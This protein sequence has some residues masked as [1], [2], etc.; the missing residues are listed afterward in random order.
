MDVP[1]QKGKL[2]IVIIWIMTNIMIL[3]LLYG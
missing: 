2:F 3:S 1:K